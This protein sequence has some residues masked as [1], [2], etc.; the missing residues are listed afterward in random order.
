MKEN[1]QAAQEEV[2]RIRFPFH[3]P[4]PRAYIK[5]DY[6]SRSD[7]LIPFINTAH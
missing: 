6:E 3:L 2:G 5:D 4:G 7:A 1:V